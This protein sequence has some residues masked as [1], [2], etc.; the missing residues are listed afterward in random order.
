KLAPPSLGNTQ[1]A[2][3]RAFLKPKGLETTKEGGGDVSV[4][5]QD[6]STTVAAFQ[7]GAIDGAWVPEPYATKLKN[8]GGKVLVDEA[9]LWPQGKFVNTNLVVTTNFLGDHPDVVAKLIKA[10]ADSIDLINNDQ[11]GSAQLVSKGIE[12]AS[13][14][15][16]AAPIVEASFEHLPYTLDP[17]A[18]SL[19]KDS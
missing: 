14:K 4:V 17:V 12:E 18:S 9:T 2:S 5:P 6:N 19:R 10:L 13:G 15:A 8:E 16:L 3:L 1:D 7:T 11:A